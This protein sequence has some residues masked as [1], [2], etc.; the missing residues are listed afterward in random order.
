MEGMELVPS[1]EAPALCVKHCAPDPSVI[2]DLATPGVPMLAW[3]PIAAT[4]KCIDDETKR[5]HHVASNYFRCER[6]Y[7][8]SAAIPR[9]KAAV[10][11]TPSSPSPAIIQPHIAQLASAIISIL[12]I[13]CSSIVVGAHWRGIDRA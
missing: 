9:I 7:F 12:P 11:S 1:Q 8:T 2:F 5:C 3:L 4:P 10:A 6:R 13:L